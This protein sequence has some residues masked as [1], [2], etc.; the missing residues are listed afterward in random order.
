MKIKKKHKNPKTI[1]YT[2][3][4]ILTADWHLTEKQPVCRTDNFWQIQWQ[5]IEEI[6]ELQ[7]KYNCPVYHAGD[8]FDFWKPSPYL[9]SKTMKHL[10][11][12]FYTIL[13]N[14]DLPQHN[15][16][17]IKKCGTYTLW[18][19]GC[20]EIFNECHWGVLPK[21]PSLSLKGKKILIWHVM[22]WTTGKQYPGDTSPPAKGLL[23][24]Y[25]DYD[26]IVT[27][28]NHKSFTE[29]YNNRLLI[30]PG[31]ITRQEAGQINHRP[32]IYLYFAETNEIEPYYLNY[33]KGV[34]SRN[35]LEE[36]ERRDTRIFA[37]IEKLNDGGVKELNFEKNIELYMEQNKIEIDIKNIV[38]KAISV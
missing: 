28:H 12:K 33:K 18:T 15:L 4:A 24:K 32:C 9:L 5:K 29:T 27:G 26:L 35:H 17:L 3:D 8:L 11:T 13:G 36:Q 16:E 38:N 22:T 6:K 30:N 21:T 20:L 25:Q 7:E 19:A 10:P 2:P 37:F 34:I 1:N 23:K 14:H 31:S